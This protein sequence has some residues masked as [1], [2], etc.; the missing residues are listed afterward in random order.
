MDKAEYRIKLEQ[1]RACAE[2]G[3]FHGAAKI[4]D[5]IDWHRVKSVRTLC[6]IS[7]I[8]EA[9]KRYEDGLEILEQAYRRS[10]QSKTVLYRLADV[11][12]KIG[13]LSDAKQYYAAF[14]EVAPQDTSRYV[15]K[16]KLL[17]A[18]KAPLDEQIAV[19]KEYKDREYTERWAYELARLYKKNGQKQRCIEE[20]DDMILWFAEGR[21]VT[22]AMEL[23]MQLVPLS[24]SP[25]AK[26][27]SRLAESKVAAE[28]E[29]KLAMETRTAADAAE[30]AEEPAETEQGTAKEPQDDMEDRSGSV[31]T[32][33]VIEKMNA[34]ADASLQGARSASRMPNVR[35]AARQSISGRT[36]GGNDM[37]NQLASS[38][39]EVFS[40]IR[41]QT[42]EESWESEERAASRRERPEEKPEPEPQAHSEE[43]AD[44]AELFAETENSIAQSVQAATS[45]SGE[46]R[47]EEPEHREAEHPVTEQNT[48][49]DA[50]ES[51]APSG[52]TEVKAE[53]LPGAAEEEESEAGKLVGMETDESL[54]LTREFNFSKELDNLVGSG[55]EA[56]SSQVRKEDH[57]AHKRIPDPEEA[58]VKIV[59]ES[60]REGEASQEEDV[61]G[62]ENVAELSERLL[63]GITEIP[64][65][66]FVTVAQDADGKSNVITAPAVKQEAAANLTPS[67]AKDRVKSSIIDHLLDEPDMIERMDV[68]PRTFDD[69][70]KKLFSYFSAIP[71][72]GEQVSIA[73]A[74]IHNNSGDRTSKSGNVLI[75]GRRGCGKTKLAESL[76]LAVCRNLN[77]PAAKT[78]KIIASDFNQKD[79]AAIVKKMAGGFLIIEGAGEL[80]ADTVDK[81]NRAMEF[82]TDDMVVILEDEKQDMKALL[83][84]YP[85]FARKFTSKITI[86]VFTND[87]LVTFGKVYAQENG[88][89]SDEMATLALY[90]MIGENQKNTEPVT[91]NMVREMVDKAIARS[92]G[93]KFQLFSKNQVGPDGRIILR[94]KD[95]AF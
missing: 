82:R 22:R 88:Y 85:E 81:L 84:K 20:C 37:Q 9:D 40:G 31:S 39:R 8:Y 26:Y 18:E 33:E 91:V 3:D 67:E 15:L 42:D 63:A 24:E 2:N 94:E 50:D 7:E 72:I 57:S 86:P 71:G 13:N 10:P 14:E 6:M 54:G 69:T 28:R 21:Y 65:S 77:I 95:F 29:E 52:T 30:D 80:S 64:A 48:D 47:P 68:V 70:E 16:Y 62:Y 73:I 44:L 66:G 45:D 75:V 46:E 49:E 4:A 5:T 90:T 87:E 78:A 32:A 92:K 83:D 1:V 36:A 17:R 38:I 93:R 35:P 25:K 56:A 61:A 43:D 60:N 79:A 34:A 41:P 74:D 53:D 23:K 27:E 58:A 11:S 51:E 76:V 12:V 19:L 59:A 89:S 55:S